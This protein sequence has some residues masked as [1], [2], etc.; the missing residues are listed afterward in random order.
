MAGNGGSTAGAVNEADEV[1][2][3]LVTHT[4]VRPVDT[5]HGAVNNFYDDKQPVRI[6]LSDLVSTGFTVL[7]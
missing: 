2:S 1:V 3:P 5:D 6:E 4:Q 7:K